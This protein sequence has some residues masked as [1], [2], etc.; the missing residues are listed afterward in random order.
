[1][2]ERQ[3][4]LAGALIAAVI[5]IF[6]YILLQPHKTN[7]IK[8]EADIVVIDPTSMDTAWRDARLNI[9]NRIGHAFGQTEVAGTI[10]GNGATGNV[11]IIPVGSNTNNTDVIK[12][13]NYTG[14]SSLR[15][16]LYGNSVAPRAIDIYN[17]V[18]SG[19]SPSLW[20]YL[21]DS[22]LGSSTAL[23]KASRSS[24]ESAASN[25]IENRAKNSPSFEAVIS[26]ITSNGIQPRQ[27]A[28]NL[29]E[30]IV[31]TAKGIVLSDAIMAGTAKP[32]TETEGGKA[33]GCSDILGATRVVS[34]LLSDLQRI[35]QSGTGKAKIEINACTLYAS[36]MMHY[37]KQGPLTPNLWDLQSD[38]GD[39]AYQFGQKAS[40]QYV[41][42]NGYPQLSGGSEVYMPYLGLTTFNK[43]RSI[44]DVNE[45]K[46]YWTGFFETAQVQ[47]AQGSSSVACSG[48]EPHVSTNRS[49]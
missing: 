31:G 40:E 32:C 48:L 14:L 10:V 29:C 7:V 17:Q 46:F 36:D 23:S 26:D 8:E 28:S 13:L 35:D 3:R 6:A 39:E 42:M 5:A 15:D 27:L 19:D 41:G 33:L 45:M 16:S 21:V 18:L 11:T 4:Y 44:H 34:T 22:Q 47:I 20:K 24:C 9:M 37:N 43:N 49:N 38:E 25:E 1:V 2:Y 12:V 30:Q